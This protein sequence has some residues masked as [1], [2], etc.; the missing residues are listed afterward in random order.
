MFYEQDILPFGRNGWHE[1]LGC[2][3][4]LLVSHGARCNAIILMYSS[5]ARAHGGIH[6]VSTRMIECVLTIAPLVR[7]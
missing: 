7:T 5:R 6:R 3:S 4:A 2:S 1:I